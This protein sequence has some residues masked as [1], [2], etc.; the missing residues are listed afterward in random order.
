M[1]AV[2]IVS[3]IVGI[4]SLVSYREKG[5]R[6]T[7]F[8][9]GIVLI[10]ITLS[11]IPTLF[12]NLKESISFDIPFDGEYD[13]SYKTVA[14]EAFE[15]GVAEAVSDRFSINKSNITVIAE[16]FDFETMRARKIRIVLSG[17]AA[18]SDYTA[19]ENYINEFD[20]GECEAEIEI[21]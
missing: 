3:F 7:R 18:F 2:F 11:P 16:G 10:Y 1:T 19:V 21:G 8:A 9:L 14:R 12:E 13:E 5:D 15:Q 20:I 6:A 4:S 17:A